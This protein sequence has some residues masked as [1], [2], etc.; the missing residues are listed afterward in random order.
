MS[1]TRLSDLSTPKAVIYFADT[2]RSNA[3]EHYLAFFGERMRRD[4]L[5]LLGIHSD[6]AMAGNPFDRIVNGAS[7]QGIRFYPILSQGLVAP[8]NSAS[9]S[10]LA[11]TIATTEPSRSNA[12]FR[13]ARDTLSSLARETGGYAFVQGQSPLSVIRD[14]YRP[15][16]NLFPVPRGFRGHRSSPVK[17]I[18]CSLL[19]HA[20]RD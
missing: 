15:K 13:Q 18:S 11:S 1:L 20:G 4:R 2:M 6:A 9:T 19:P 17:F 14:Y 8:M 16:F 12:R 3:G 10:S 7:A 5:P